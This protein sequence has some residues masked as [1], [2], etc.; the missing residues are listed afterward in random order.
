[1]SKQTK[2]QHHSFYW[3]YATLGKLIIFDD[4]DDAS[5]TKITTGF[6]GEQLLNYLEKLD[7]EATNC[8]GCGGILPELHIYKDNKVY[9]FTCVEIREG[10]E[11]KK[12]TNY[13][14]LGKWCIVNY[15]KRRNS[16]KS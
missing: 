6:I 4:N 7:K 14:K 13:E 3:V 1:M 8:I 9:N 10:L 15:T 2:G 11:V 5:P 12:K 16:F